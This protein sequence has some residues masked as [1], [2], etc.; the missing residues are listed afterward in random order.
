MGPSASHLEPE[1]SDQ[2]NRDH[3]LAALTTLQNGFTD[4]DLRAIFRSLADQFCS[5]PASGSDE[6]EA[7]RRG[8]PASSKPQREQSETK[9]VKQEEVK[10]DDKTAQPDKVENDVKNANGPKDETKVDEGEESDI[11]SVKAEPPPPVLIINSSTHRKEHARL[12]RRMAAADV[13]ASCPEM[14]R[15]WSGS[16]KDKF[17]ELF[18]TST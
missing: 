17:Y 6:L 1:R 5:K 10:N 18:E 3:L 9:N 7:A 12:A 16:R 13:A 2:L 4:P 11:D 8:E 15:L 14:Y